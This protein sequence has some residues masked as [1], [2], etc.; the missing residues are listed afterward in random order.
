MKKWLLVAMVVFSFC[1]LASAQSVSPIES[2]ISATPDSGTPGQTL[3]SVAIAGSGTE[4]Q[5]KG[6]KSVDFGSGITVGSITVIDDANLTVSNAAISASADYGQRTVTVI[7]NDDTTISANI[8]SVIDPLWV[9]QLSEADG[10]LYDVHIVSATV[11]YAVGDNDKLWKTTDGINWSSSSIMNSGDPSIV[12][13]AV[14]FNADTGYAAGTWQ[15]PG[16]GMYEPLIYKTINGGA[17]WS[18]VSPPDFGSTNMI[19]D[20]YA[21]GS[22]VWAAAKG[23]MFG[24][25][26]KNF[27]YSTDGGANW[28]AKTVTYDVPD[29][30]G[31]FT[32]MTPSCFGVYATG[33]KVWAVG[34]WDPAGMIGFRLGDAAYKSVYL[35]NDGGANF[36]AALDLSYLEKNSFP[37]SN[38]GFAA[39][40]DGTNGYIYKSTDGG[41]NWT[42][43]T[44][45]SAPKPLKAVNFTN[46]SR[47]WTVGRNGEIL[48]TTDSGASWTKH[49]RDARD[50]NGVYCLDAN[51]V[52]AVGGG[53]TAATKPFIII[54]RGA[55]GGAPEGPDQGAIILKYS[56]TTTT[57]TTTTTTI[58][59]TSSQPK[60]SMPRQIQILKNEAQIKTLQVLGSDFRSGL[61]VKL[62]KVGSPDVIFFGRDITVSSDSKSV[63]VT[64]DIPSKN[65]RYVGAYDITVTNPDGESTAFSSGFLVEWPEGDVFLYR[66]PGV[67]FSAMRAA[68]PAQQARIAYTL[69]ADKSIDILVYDV[70]EMKVVYRRKIAAGQ[71]PGGAYGYN[72]IPWN[73]LTDLGTAIPNGTY[74]LQVVSGGKIVGQ[75]YF[76]VRD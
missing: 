65:E 29:G 47:G 26:V 64:F 52:W 31:G 54:I 39:G 10:V 22:N 70:R 40:N 59:K 5:A 4:F 71:S 24:G 37:D 34:G 6:V 69:S 55:G 12:W 7:Y 9:I 72:E 62:V 8:F 61:K 56:V 60:I 76:V 48:G 16:T 27:F 73:G 21:S 41:T 28:T 33:S 20:I 57:T 44:P 19:Y 66:P 46:A 36:T 38:T 53:I 42:A 13:Y 68:A 2:L 11:G 51:N 58:P 50:L 35:S 63:T 14:H 30:K 3:S 23:D 15:N 17:S 25:G 43:A 74:V 67:K 18:N 75:T 1:R 32:T 49:F 45:A